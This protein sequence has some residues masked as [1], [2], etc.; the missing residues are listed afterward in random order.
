MES[1]VCLLRATEFCDMHC[2]TNGT[3]A[4][5]EKSSQG[6]SPQHRML[7]CADTHSIQGQ[8]KLEEWRKEAT[9]LDS[10]MA[11]S[12][13]RVALDPRPERIRDKVLRVINT[14]TFTHASDCQSKSSSCGDRQAST[15]TARASL[16]EK[17]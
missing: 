2:V 8:A 5:V 3:I 7:R 4:K 15:S 11:V 6:K 10:V 1:A 16:T 17:R 9:C 13:G 12:V 14:S